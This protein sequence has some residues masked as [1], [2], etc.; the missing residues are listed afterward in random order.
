[1]ALLGPKDDPAKVRGL[2]DAAEAFRR[3]AS[4]K[5]PFVLNDID[6]VRYL[7]EIL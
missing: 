1:M 3:I 6:G 4:T 5:S 7:T 2:E